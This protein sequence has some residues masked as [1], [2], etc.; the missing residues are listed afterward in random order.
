VEQTGRSVLLNMDQS[1]KNGLQDRCSFSPN[2]SFHPPIP[3]S[4]VSLVVRSDPS[5]TLALNPHPP[6]PDRQPFRPFT[7]YLSTMRFFALLTIIPLLQVASATVIRGP[8]HDHGPHP[9]YC[10]TTV[11]TMTH[12]Q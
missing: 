11:V 5:D 9:P 1:I 8:E 4:F 10:G 12:V 7:L 3:H 6:P 2:A